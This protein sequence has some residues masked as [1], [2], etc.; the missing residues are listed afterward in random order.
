VSAVANSIAAAV[1]E[2]A[3]ATEEIKRSTEEA[4]RRSGEVSSNMVHVA[5]T[6]EK[7]GGAAQGVQDTAKVLGTEADRLREEVH[8][9]LE[10][11]RAA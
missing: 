8:G 3:A 5:D 11:M 9:F 2:Q 1:R 10:K 7:T 6:T 4:A